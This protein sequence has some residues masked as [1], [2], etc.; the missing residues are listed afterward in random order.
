MIDF[1]SDHAGLIGLIF[2]VSVFLIILIYVFRPG[3][4]QKYKSHGNI[5]FKGD[6]NG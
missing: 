6:D 2:F 5:P 1:L 3:S 4:K